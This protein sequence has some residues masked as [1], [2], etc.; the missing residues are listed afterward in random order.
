MT[1]DEVF[2]TRKRTTR[3]RRL[4]TIQLP[5]AVPLDFDAVTRRSS[6]VDVMPA[7]GARWYSVPEK[8]AATTL[9]AD[10]M[11]LSRKYSCPSLIDVEYLSP[12]APQRR[13]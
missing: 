13:T 10:V 3:L 7:A 12:D 8:K 2:H 6:K 5:L 9:Q 11:C 1:R 4:G